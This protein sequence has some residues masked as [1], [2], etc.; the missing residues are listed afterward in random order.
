MDLE[1]MVQQDY[2]YPDII[3]YEYEGD[4]EK[5]AKTAVHAG[6]TYFIR[7]RNVSDND[8]A[9]PVK[10]QYTLTLHVRQHFT[11][12]NEMNDS[13]EQATNSTF[14]KIYAGTFGK[15]DED[16]YKVKVKTP[17]FLTAQLANIPT[18]VH[19]TATLLTNNGDFVESKDIRA[20][21]NTVVFGEKVTAGT[22]V[23]QLTSD[24]PF[25]EMRYKIKF[26]FNSLIAGYRDI[27][28]IANKSAVIRLVKE[29]VLTPDAD[30][31]FYP[32]Q[33]ITRADAAAWVKA[34]LHK[35]KQAIVTVTKRN[36][37]EPISRA[38]SAEIICKMLGWKGKFGILKPYDDV[39][40]RYW[41][42]KYIRQVKD[43]KM[44]GAVKP[45]KFYPEKPVTREAFAK[46]MVEVIDHQ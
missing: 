34:V 14:G 24:R 37:N 11:D 33:V 26:T 4:T 43:K 19:V 31:Y 1:L 39:G 6:T 2:E 18:N 16:Y 32:N 44:M 20:P 21:K 15:A 28:G 45:G 27:A 42:I 35:Q 25:D 8:T 10:A 5:L 29:K 30:A 36:Q 12:N 13:I 9:Y 7:V 40:Y 41:A 38:Q 46:Y 3:D 22:Y 23:I 17:G